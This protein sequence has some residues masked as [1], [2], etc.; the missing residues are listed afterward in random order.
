MIT[1]YIALALVP[2][3]IFLLFSL[4]KKQAKTPVSAEPKGT[5][6]ERERNIALN[7]TPSLLKLAIPEDEILVYGVV[8]DMDMGEGFMSLACYITGAANLHFS[9]GSGIRGGGRNPN[10]GEAGVELVTDAQ[11]FLAFATPVKVLLPP[12]KKTVQFFFLTNKG[13]YFA[14]ENVRYIEDNSSKWLPL[15]EKASKVITEMHKGSKPQ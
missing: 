6:Y 5:F 10:V 7:I 4:K 9:A 14:Q 8:V 15:F 13:K 11:D 12:S 1:L 3:A 2:V